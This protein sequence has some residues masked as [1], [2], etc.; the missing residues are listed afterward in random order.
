[1]SAKKN[2]EKDSLMKVLIVTTSYYPKSGGLET[3][4]RNL[5][6]GL[7]RKGHQV[8][9][10]THNYGESNP[11]EIHEGIE[12]LRIGAYLKEL[13]DSN[14]IP[15]EVCFFSILDEMQTVLEEQKFDV[16]HAHT[17]A[18][19]FICSSLKLHFHCPLVFSPHET[20][21]ELEGFGIARSSMLIKYL[22]YD[23][24]VVGSDYFQSQCLEFGATTEQIVQ[25]P[26]GIP[27]L[28]TNL[29]NSSNSRESLAQVFDFDLDQPLMAV[30][31]RYK[32]RKGQLEAI[33]AF[34]QVVESFPKANLMLVGSCHSASQAYLQ[35]LKE[36]VHL[37]NL[38][39]R[40]TFAE[41]VED[42]IR[43]LAIDAADIVVQPSHIEGYG[44]S[45]LE[46]LSL[47][48]ALVATN[49]AGLSEFLVDQFSCLLVPPNSPDDLAKAIVRLLGDDSIRH[50]LELNARAQ[51]EKKHSLDRM[52]D[53]TIDAYK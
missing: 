26:Y 22:P 34:S 5:V 32:K 3:H 28:A 39:D 10:L 11:R 51:Y 12:I 46:A 50:S 45:A 40:V 41:N 33:R 24:C 38:T 8:T 47:G 23:L 52:V 36:E 21:T 16:I 31:G 14:S 1:M 29:K 35:Q 42:Y 15:W 48:K 13:N 49:V 20:T 18:S 44:L 53:Q 43:D 30:I 37:L 2:S 17:Q 4:C 9:V 7:A 6:E 27:D 25:V 19:L